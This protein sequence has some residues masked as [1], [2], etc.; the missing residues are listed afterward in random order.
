MCELEIDFEGAGVALNWAGFQAC[1]GASPFGEVLSIHKC[2]KL[3]KD[4]ILDMN[5]N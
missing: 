5:F 3:K 4:E 1:H 2:K